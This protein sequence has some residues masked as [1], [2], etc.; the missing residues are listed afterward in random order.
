MILRQKVCIVHILL[1]AYQLPQFLTTNSRKPQINVKE[2]L[3]DS[4]NIY[5][6]LH[7]LDYYDM[8]FCHIIKMTTTFKIL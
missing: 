5:T 8:T 2:P 6:L 4:L 1:D 3:F 7:T